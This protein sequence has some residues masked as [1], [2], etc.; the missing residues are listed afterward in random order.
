MIL[1][2]YHTNS[3]IGWGVIGYGGVGTYNGGVTVKRIDGVVQ[4]PDSAST[5][6]ANI[7]SAMS[8][9]WGL[10][11]QVIIWNVDSRYFADWMNLL[12]IKTQVAGIIISGFALIRGV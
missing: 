9:I 3:Q 5:S 11:L 4:T 7:L 6:E 1:S 8:S 12:F 10:V 2:N